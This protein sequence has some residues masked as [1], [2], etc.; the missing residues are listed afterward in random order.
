MLLHAGMH[1]LLIGRW[2]PEARG[3]QVLSLAASGII[4]LSIGDQALM[5]AFIDIGPRLATLVMT[6]A[7][8]VAA[9]FGWAVLGETLAWA[10]WLGIGLTVF[11]TAWA[12][13]ERPVLDRPP[14]LSR[15]GTQVPGSPRRVK[16]VLCALVGAVC[17]A[18]GLL[19]S[20]RGMGHGWLPAEEH[21][22]PQTATL[23][24]MTFAG[25]GMLPLLGV[26]MARASFH[27]QGSPFSAAGRTHSGVLLA[28]LGAVTGPFLG[29][30]M[31]LVASDRVPLG[32]AQTLCSF[33]PILILP[34][35]AWL[36]TE[37][38]G[39]RALIGALAAVGGLVIL[40]LSP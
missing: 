28:A 16:G 38:I 19:L 3:G 7:P 32:V 12:V 22:A 27:S 11:G 13:L 15:T 14:M 2:L 4:G 37:R 6:T 1:R 26:H 21:I 25:L 24:R 29:V 20:K 35:A 5:Q 23:I 9:L 39:P 40:F 8:L 31:S 30:W 10:S 18:G 36:H 17:Q 33:T 34:F